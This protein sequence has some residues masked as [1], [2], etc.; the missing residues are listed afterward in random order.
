M[1]IKEIC[2]MMERYVEEE[3]QEV[4]IEYLD[5]WNY[6]EDVLETKRKAL[7]ARR[8]GKSSRGGGHWPSTVVSSP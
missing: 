8:T 5:M 3:L 6:M 2:L 1:S 7:M 4:L